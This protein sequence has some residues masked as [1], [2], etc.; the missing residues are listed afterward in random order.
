MLV[1][2]HDGNFESEIIAAK[3]PALVDF[4]AAWC[5]PCK[6]LEPIVKELDQDLG[7]RVKIAKVDV[8]EAQELAARFGIT[9]VP[10]IIFFKD[11]QEAGRSI[12]LQS[13]EN[14]QKK[15]SSHL[16]VAL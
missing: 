12:G 4:G 16:G 15:I 9:S 10:T 13:R 11:G 3:V 14:L 8:D 7:G 6:Q 1:H 5:G 2:I